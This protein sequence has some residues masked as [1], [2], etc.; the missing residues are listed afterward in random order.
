M[1]CASTSMSAG[2]S[3]HCLA[4]L[5]PVD[6]L[7]FANLFL[8]DDLSEWLLVVLYPAT[9]DLFYLYLGHGLRVD[10]HVGRSISIIFL[11]LIVSVDSLCFRL[12]LSFMG[13]LN[14]VVAGGLL[15]LLYEEQYLVTVD[16]HVLIYMVYSC[17]L[18]FSCLYGYA[19]AQP[20][21]R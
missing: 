11:S 21:E 17:G 8:W 5:F 15:W 1:V 14:R 19:I 3:A 2:Q 12:S 16:F 20:C 4:W 10:F 13:W 9:V 7:W 6:S 18:I